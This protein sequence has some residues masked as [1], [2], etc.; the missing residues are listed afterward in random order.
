MHYSNI[1]SVAAL[2]LAATVAADTLTVREVCYFTGCGYSGTFQTTAGLY[3]VPAG[4]GC[5]RNP[6]PPGMTEPHFRK[7]WRRRL[8][9]S[10]CSRP[11][12]ERKG[13]LH[14]KKRTMR[15]RH[16]RCRRSHKRRISYL[17]GCRSSI[18]HPLVSHS[19]SVS[20]N[21][22]PSPSSNEG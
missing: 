19:H 15:Q 6:G 13:I 8:W 3:I 16:M 21:E 1:I 9:Q 18:T 4:D 7:S 14:L 2:G 22:F 20:V 12:E 11:I 10:S 17:V 5:H